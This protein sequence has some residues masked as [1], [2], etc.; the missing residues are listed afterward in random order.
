M[1]PPNERSNIRVIAGFATGLVVLVG[2]IALAPE[3][4]VRPEN[5]QAPVK[6]VV[7]ENPVKAPAVTTPAILATPKP[8][9][10]PVEETIETASTD[11]IAQPPIPETDTQQATAP[12]VAA[13]IVA[14]QVPS[15]TLQD[16]QKEV[17]P[18]ARDLILAMMELTS[19]QSNSISEIAPTLLPVSQPA[20][21]QTIS[22]TKRIVNFRD[23][24][25]APPLPFASPPPPPPQEDK[26]ANAIKTEIP[27]I[28]PIQP[29][30][31]DQPEPPAIVTLDVPKIAPQAPATPEA[32][33]L[34]VRSPE[35]VRVSVNSFGKKNAG[36]ESRTS[37]LLAAVT[38]ADRIPRQGFTTSV[39]AQ[40]A[41]L[42]PG[43]A[44]STAPPAPP[45]A[46]GPAFESFAAT[47]DDTS[48]KALLAVILI[49]PGDEGMDRNFL[50]NLSFPV[51]FAVP[52][53]GDRAQFIDAEY[54]QKGFETVAM[55]PPS[56]PGT[57]L[58]RDRT[59]VVPDLIASYRQAVPGAIGLMD[60]PGG[61]LHQN[62]RLLRVLAGDLAKSGHAMLTNKQRINNSDRI[63]QEAGIAFAKV[64][65][66][67]D[68][69][70]S[71]PSIRR[72]LERAALTASKAGGAVIVGHSQPETIKTL[73]EW[74]LSNSA[75][76]INVAP[77]SA[78]IKRLGQG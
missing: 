38:G 39:V 66:P 53:A 17:S 44:E 20:P 50:K 51:T 57:L 62:S 10:Q 65:R 60:F 31:V 1:T 28:E 59:N 11:P 9:Q 29:Q 48:G 58:R 23:I 56:G 41:P 6:T 67:I 64:L 54:R 2:G 8:L 52:A 70:G 77:V 71:V 14:P 49:D 4:D 40:E 18:V 55:V 32:A 36:Q 22:V 15:V 37:G 63:A 61:E 35:P 12:K 3:M 72:A 46:T 78:V 43:Q 27:V 16:P 25:D 76:S 13:P 45:I 30:V 74:I 21:N 5:G 69:D 68:A 7:D 75:R 33:D 34:G 47:Y 42:A 24:K 19:S 73:Y 26:I